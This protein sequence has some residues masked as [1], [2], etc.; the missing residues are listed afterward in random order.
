MAS[1]RL[2]CFVLLSLVSFY[3]K[4]G[5]FGLVLWM[6]IY[7]DGLVLAYLFLCSLM[8]WPVCDV[9]I[10]IVHSVAVYYDGLV[11]ARSCI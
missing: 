2:V 7:Y 9:Q 5:Q 3:F 4:D 8:L 10:R 6:S 1:L 11:S